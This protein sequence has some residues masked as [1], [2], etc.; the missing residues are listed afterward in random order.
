MIQHAKLPLLVPIKQIQVEVST[1]VDI[2]QPHFNV[3]HYKGSW[4]VISLRSPE[5][6]SEQII[7]DLMGN[8]TYA[9]TPLLKNCPTIKKLLESFQC[10]MMAARLMNLS[11]GSVIR[12]HCDY[13]LAYEKGE[14]RLHFPITTNPEVVFYVNN[15]CVIMQEGECWY[16]NVNL[17]HRVKNDGKSNRIH[18]VVD[19]VVNDW[20]K[21]L[22]TRADVKMAKNI[23]QSNETL[24]IIRELRIQ[25]SEKSNQ[26]ADELE[27]QFKE[28]E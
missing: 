22:F 19:C 27:Q 23:Q 4:T 20:L 16:V 11:P 15:E 17:P 28:V 14:A 26:L 7:P 13:D 12:E 18:L 6:A 9:E 8:Q 2:W 3:K 10:P 1:L 25:N 5:G 21:D 24:K